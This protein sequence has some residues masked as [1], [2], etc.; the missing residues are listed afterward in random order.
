V[1]PKYSRLASELRGRI[2]AGEFP[3][4]GQLPSEDQLCR[5]SGHSRGTVRMALDVLERAGIIRRDQGRG[6]FVNDYAAAFEARMFGL[7]T[8]EHEIA[9]QGRTP[10][11]TILDAE[12]RKA[13]REIGRILQID[14]TSDVIYIRRLLF[15]DGKPLAIETRCMDRRLRPDL[16]HL[17]PHEDFQVIAVGQYRVPIARLTQSVEK[18]FPEPED[19]ALLGCQPG[20]AVF[21]LDRLT[22]TAGATRDAPYRPA[23][24][25]RTVQREEVYTLEFQPFMGM[26]SDPS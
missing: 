13:K 15:A 26:L 25:I 10:S 6:T 11:V 16:E 8:F 9:K 14:P 5:D 4:G 3:V 7:A 12:F 2:E 22:H 17:S 18:V 19:A 21:Q 20:E 23:V 1:E 24:W